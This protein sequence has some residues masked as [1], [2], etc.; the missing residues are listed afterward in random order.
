MK[1]KNTR[2]I[3]SNWLIYA[4]FT[5]FTSVIRWAEFLIK[6]LYLYHV[7]ERLRFCEIAKKKKKIKLYGSIYNFYLFQIM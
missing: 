7:I 4:R 6:N 1:K 2:N 3:I 5:C